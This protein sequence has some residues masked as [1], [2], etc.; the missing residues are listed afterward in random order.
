MRDD[1]E[2]TTLNGSVARALLRQMKEGGRDGEMNEEVKRQESPV[3][4]SPSSTSWSSGRTGRVSEKVA[5]DELVCCLIICKSS[6]NASSDTLLFHEQQLTYFFPPHY[7]HHP[8]SPAPHPPIPP[9][10]PAPSSHHLLPSAYCLTSILS[11]SLQ[12]G[13][14]LTV[15]IGVFTTRTACNVPSTGVPAAQALPTSCEG[16][17]ART[18][19]TESG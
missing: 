13:E 8:H 3:D 4:F 6:S 19:R 5:R 7:P 17:R 1:E 9:R 2:S 11:S 12:S 15:K 18:L 10:N 14:S 16:A